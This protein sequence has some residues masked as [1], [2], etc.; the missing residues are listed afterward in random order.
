MEEYCLSL[1][2]HYPELRNR[3]GE[4][5]ADYFERSENRELFLAWL[6]S[7]ALDSMREKL[8]IILQRHLEELL[9]KDFPPLREGEPE[10]ALA[11][12]LYRLRERRLMGLKAKE[13]LLMAEAESAADAAQLEELK[14]SALKLNVQLKE[15]FRRKK[16]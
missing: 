5:S 7:P 6:N 15:I 3:A 14:Q 8:D 12:C 11:D 10:R 1:L 9:A 2:L 13:E 4:L 16:A